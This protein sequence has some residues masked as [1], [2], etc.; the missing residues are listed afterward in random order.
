FALLRHGVSVERRRDC[1]RCPGRVLKD[2][3]DTVTEVRSHIDRQQHGQ[4]LCRFECERETRGESDS[5][6]SR[7]AGKKS[8][9]RSDSEPNEERDDRGW[10]GEETEAFRNCTHRGTFKSTANSVYRNAVST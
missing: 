6:G 7:D 1:R 3:R 2:R 5:H 4:S 8:Y 10:V 9:Y